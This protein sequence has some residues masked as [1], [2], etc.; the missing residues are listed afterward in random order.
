MITRMQIEVN[1]QRG[2]SVPGVMNS[3]PTRA[4]DLAA[5]RE[6]PVESAGIDGSAMKEPSWPMSNASA[7]LISSGVSTRPAR[8]ARGSACPRF[9]AGRVAGTRLLLSHRTVETQVS[10]LLQGKARSRR[11]DDSSASGPA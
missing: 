1:E 2:T 7:A 11:E 9:A 5:R 6:F 3:E 10:S 4:R 8:S